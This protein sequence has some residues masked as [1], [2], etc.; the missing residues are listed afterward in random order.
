MIYYP[1]EREGGRKG[2]S[3]IPSIEDNTGSNNDFTLFLPSLSLSLCLSA[4][5]LISSSRRDHA[6]VSDVKIRHVGKIDLWRAFTGAENEKRGSDQR[7]SGG[8]GEIS[9]VKCGES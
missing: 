4:F 2:P 7:E 8:R 5:L 3:S 6:H 9:M 1:R